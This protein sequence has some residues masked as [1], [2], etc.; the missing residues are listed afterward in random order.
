MLRV[1]LKKEKQKIRKTPKLPN[2]NLLIL[3]N[4]GEVTHCNLAIFS[5]FFFEVTMLFCLSVYIIGVFLVTS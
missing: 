5:K 3:I 1:R 4:L 2:S